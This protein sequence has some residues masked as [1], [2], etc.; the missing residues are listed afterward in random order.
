MGSREGEEDMLSV[1]VGYNSSTARRGLNEQEG[2]TRD[3]KELKQKNK[4]MGGGKG[5]KTQ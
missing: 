1:K 4:K 3:Y 5:K 2:K